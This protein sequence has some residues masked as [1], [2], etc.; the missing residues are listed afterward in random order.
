MASKT[1]PPATPDDDVAFR[2]IRFG[3]WL[4]GVSVTLGIVVEMLHGFK[5]GWYLDVGNEMRRLMLTLAH[6]HGTWIAIVNM[7]AGY[8]AKAFGPAFLPAKPAAAIRIAGVL[9]P[10][11]FFLGGLVIHDGDPGIGVFLVPIGGFL[12]LYGVFAVAAAIHR[13]RG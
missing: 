13:S 10:L 1:A 4:L 11:G 12:M 2:S 8:G 7:A 3:W 5:V 9:M 6:T